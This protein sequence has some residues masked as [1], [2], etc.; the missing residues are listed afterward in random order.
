M[1]NSDQSVHKVAHK[2]T[3]KRTLL[4]TVVLCVVCALLVSTAAVMLRPLQEENQTIDRQRNILIAAGLLQ[5]DVPIE[6]Q[7]QQITTKVVD[8]RTGYYTQAVDPATYN[9]LQAAKNPQMS[10]TLNRQEDVAKIFRRED[11]AVVYLVEKNGVLD[12]VILPVRGYGL[13]STMYGFIALDK[14]L[15]TIAGLGFYQQ[16]E[17]PGLGGEID[18]PRWLAEWPGKHVYEDNNVAIHL[19]KGV[20]NPA[21]P[22]QAFEVDGLA[23]AT[24][25][26][27][28]VTNLLKFW[29]GPQGFQ[30]FLDNLKAG[31]A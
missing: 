10:E 15:N 17:T 18:N 19:V 5:A 12:K 20:V 25:T 14:D 13:W 6:Q 2:D 8:L 3:V 27:R 29:L 16:G 4:V 21:S 30:P 22:D 9:A 24:L 11:Y 7:F 31:S 28:G 26:S 23:G 1:A